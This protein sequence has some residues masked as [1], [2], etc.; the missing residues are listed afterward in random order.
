M[1][2]LHAH[3]QVMVGFLSFQGF[4]KQIPSAALRRSDSNTRLSS[5]SLFQ[6]GATVSRACI[7]RSVY[8]SAINIVVY[9]CHL[10]HQH[11]VQAS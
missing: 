7:Q 5:I 10:A 3:Q 2:Y 9:H 8:T 1:F 11:V 4:S 6:R